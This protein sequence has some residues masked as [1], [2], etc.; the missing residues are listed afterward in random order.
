MSGIATGVLPFNALFAK[1][2]PSMNVVAI[3]STDHVRHGLLSDQ[4]N[5]L[6]LPVWLKKLQKD[7]FFQNG[8]NKGHKDLL[9]FQFTLGSKAYGIQLIEGRVWMQLNGETNEI[10]QQK[11]GARFKAG[12]YQ[13]TFHQEE[14]LMVHALDKEEVVLIPLERGCRVNRQYLSENELLILSGPAQFQIKSNTKQSLLI[15]SNKSST[16]KN[17][18]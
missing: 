3:P 12:S 14:Q 4:V 11:G 6:N 15:L 2:A 1:P 9:S 10:A 8:I 16:W 7:V 5:Q 18:M 13:I 17:Q